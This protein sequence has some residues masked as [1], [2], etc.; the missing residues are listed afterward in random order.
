MNSMS[1]QQVPGS[2]VRLTRRGRR[3]RMRGE[4]TADGR[5]GCASEARR[6]RNGRAGDE[7][8]TAVVGTLV[9]FLIFML[10]LLVAVQVLV[11]LYATS[12]LTS[13]A[14][15]AARRVA[16][17]TFPAAAVPE[18]QAAAVRQLGSFGGRH[19]AFLWREVDGQQIVLE[20]Q[21]DAPG[22]TPI[23]GLRHIVRTV[24]VRTE[25]VR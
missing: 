19:T 18:A 15:S 13:A 7:R 14:F 20:V 4:R 16:T 11:R 23:P 12:A 5:D 3:A 8:G 1:D 17:A 24:T 10:F 6:G 21:A 25:R 22:F 9:G 2:V